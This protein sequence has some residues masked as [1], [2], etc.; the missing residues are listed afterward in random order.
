MYKESLKFF[1]HLAQGTLWRVVTIFYAF[2]H[3]KKR[4]W[5]GIPIL[6]PDR[7]H[8]VFLYIKFSIKHHSVLVHLPTKFQLDESKFAWVRQFWKNSQ[9]IQNLKKF[10]RSNRFWPNSIPKFLDGCNIFL[11]SFRTIARILRKLNPFI[12][13]FKIP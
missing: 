5:I 7:F 3:H 8:K 1:W 6:L 2:R 12:K 11:C 10:E 9:K 13:K 4:M